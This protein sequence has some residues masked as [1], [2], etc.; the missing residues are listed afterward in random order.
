MISSEQFTVSNQNI[1]NLHIKVNLLNFS[2]QTIDSLEG[3]A[4]DGSISIDANSDIRRTCNVQLVVTD[5]TFDVQSGGKIFL[6]RYIQIYIGIENIH[7]DDIVWFNQG[8]YLINAPSYSFNATTNTLTFTGV[9]LMA[10]MT[11]LRN[12]TL[13]GTMYK[14]PQGSDIRG[15]MIAVLD[16]AGFKKYVIEKNTTTEI[17]PI[18]LEFD[19]GSTQFDILCGLR[20]IEP[21]HQIYFDVD[22][23]FHYDMIPSGKEEISVMDDSVLGQ[24]VIEESISVDF[25]GVKNSIEVFGRAHDVNYF[26]TSTT[27]NDNVVSLTIE[28]LTSLSEFTMIGFVVPSDVTGNIQITIGTL[29]T[30]NLV[31]SKGQSITSLDKD[32]YYVATYQKD[33]TWLF[34][35]HQQ[36]YGVVKDTNPDSPFYIGNP[37]GEI[38]LPLFGGEYENIPS[39][40]LAVQ[41]AE[42]E[43]Y[44]RCRLNDTLTLTTVPFY[45]LTVH[46][47][48]SYTPKA[49]NSKRATY[50]YMIQSI[51]FSLNERDAMTINASKYY[52]FYEVI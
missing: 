21:Q 17:V 3:N 52:P 27:V 19:Q 7:T 41:R 14:I 35:G 6:D 10:K 29:G 16:L 23:V 18:D 37:V 40:E 26:S 39:D 47:L 20:D 49:N 50:Q 8:I 28:S 2:Y 43:I 32:G 51:N 48:I 1:R 44:T 45:Y 25:E 5:S 34:L 30:H 13:V 42:F 12:G 36:A 22:G 24:S 15:A 46:Q 38:N 9:D 31:D 4:I 33:N 11:G